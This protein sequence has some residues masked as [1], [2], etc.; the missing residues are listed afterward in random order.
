LE[1]FNRYR[2]ELLS[3]VA[4]NISTVEDPFMQKFIANKNRKIGIALSFS[5][6]IPYQNFIPEYPYE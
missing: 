4:E 3:L 2:S 6:E 5:P 1:Q